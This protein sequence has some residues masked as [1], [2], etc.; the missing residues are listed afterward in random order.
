VAASWRACAPAQHARPR[1]ETLCFSTVVTH[2]G[3]ASRTAARTRKMM[4]MRVDILNTRPSDVS[5][6]FITQSYATIPPTGTGAVSVVAPRKQH[7][8]PRV[9]PV[10]PCPTHLNTPRPGVNTGNPPRAPAQLRS[11]PP[12]HL[13][14][15][16]QSTPNTAARLHGCTTQ[17]RGPMSWGVGGGEW[18]CS[19]GP[20]M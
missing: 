5:R 18:G 1:M 19:S 3:S 9:Y 15:H 6:D 10:M 14:P 2:V 17:R 20:G 12:H 11:A 4:M 8:L 16:L 13:P 7:L